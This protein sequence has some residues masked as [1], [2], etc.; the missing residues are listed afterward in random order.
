[1]LQMRGGVRYKDTKVIILKATFIHH[2]QKTKTKNKR[3]NLGLFSFHFISLRP[4]RLKTLSSLRGKDF[5]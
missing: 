2:I 4:K 5:L 3:G 1:M